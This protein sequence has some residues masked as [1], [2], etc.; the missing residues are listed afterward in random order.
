MQSHVPCDESGTAIKQWSTW[1]R[2]SA[3]RSLVSR[4][5]WQ[6]IPMFGPISTA[7]AG[8]N[9]PQGQ[10]SR[11]DPPLCSTSGVHPALPRGRPREQI[12]PE[13]AA[14]DADSGLFAPPS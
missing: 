11:H 3:V 13:T 9:V 7:E 2:R 10:T 14:T 6:E 12:A 1:E 5:A 8:G 4:V